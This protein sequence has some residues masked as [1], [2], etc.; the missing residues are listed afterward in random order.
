MQLDEHVAPE[1]VLADHLGPLHP[2]VRALRD[3]YPDAAQRGVALRAL[4]AVAE[5]PGRLY[6]GSADEWETIGRALAK[7]DAPAAAHAL[8]ELDRHLFTLDVRYWAQRR[9]FRTLAA[10]LARADDAAAATLLRDVRSAQALAAHASPAVLAG[11]AQRCAGASSTETLALVAGYRPRSRLPG[12]AG[13]EL[14]AVAEIVTVADRA[15]H[16]DAAAKLVEAFDRDADPPPLRRASVLPLV[17]RLVAEASA[18]QP[19]AMNSF[20]AALAAL[21]AVPLALDASAVAKL[22][23]AL[24]SLSATSAELCFVQ[25]ARLVGEFQ[26]EAVPFVTGELAAK[27]DA[28][29]ATVRA[30]PASEEPVP[31]LDTVATAAAWSEEASELVCAGL[32]RW[33]TLV[34]AAHHR[35]LARS[36]AQLGPL[37]PALGEDALDRLA[38]VAHALAPDGRCELFLRHAGELGE[39]RAEVV[40][41]FVALAA[42][43]KELGCAERLDAL[44]G[45]F[46][47]ERILRTPWAKRLP[48]A[49]TRLSELAEPWGS[50]LWCA[51]LG[52][53]LSAAESSPES[54]LALARGLAERLPAMPVAARLPYLRAVHELV[55]HY[56]VR[57]VGYALTDLARSMD[58][59][60]PRSA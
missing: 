1:S 5:N 34:P 41:T 48:R 17:A 23:E 55:H 33:V 54:A 47:R 42:A 25:A 31:W 43:A 32:A 12:R 9:R 40:E 44:V 60:A 49:L 22:R 6:P 13:S 30:L 18:S 51:A 14:E 28:L 19:A 35:A 57:F 52:P 3:A 11:I 59:A 24:R 2:A 20:L 38:E 21:A 4:R 53:C 27:I 26:I 10:A 8:A 29:A 50:E 39:T 45:A 58:A 36:L 46:H 37:V 16:R 7:L 15:G 56:G